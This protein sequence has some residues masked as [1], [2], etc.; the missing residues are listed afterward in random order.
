MQDALFLLHH[1]LSQKPVTS[2]VTSST[3]KNPALEKT[4][5][6]ETGSL[7]STLPTC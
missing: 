2:A 5:A 6:R 3:N 1:Q 4:P 7:H